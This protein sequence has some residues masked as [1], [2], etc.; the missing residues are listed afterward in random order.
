M[1]VQNGLKI[2]LGVGLEGAIFLKSPPCA[3]AQITLSRYKYFIFNN[4]VAS[5][6]LSVYLD[7]ADENDRFKR[8]DP[9]RYLRDHEDKLV[10]L[11]EVHRVPEISQPFRGIIDR[12]RRG[13]RANGRFLLLDRPR[14]KSWGAAGGKLHCPSG[15]IFLKSP[16]NGI[17]FL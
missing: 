10:V 14:R 12:G 2:V 6:G 3:S 8:L 15:A 7:L 4:M 13:G 17:E 1:A 9:N 16:P 5:A 11:D